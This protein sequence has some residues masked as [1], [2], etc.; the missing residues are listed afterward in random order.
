M[1]NDIMNQN[2]DFQMES[3]DE[4][5]VNLSKALSLLAAAVDQSLKL[6]IDDTLKQ[7]IAKEWEQAVNTLI[8]YVKSQARKDTG[9]LMSW[10]SKIN[11]KL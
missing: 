10:I 8:S 3:L 11:L 2:R 7:A 5:R 9:N 4:L 1:T 6:S